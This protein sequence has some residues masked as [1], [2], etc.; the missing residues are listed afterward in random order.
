M[1]QSAYY[2]YKYYPVLKNIINTKTYMLVHIK[3]ILSRVSKLFFIISN[4]ITL[5]MFVTFLRP[6]YYVQVNTFQNG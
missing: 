6:T 3:C 1:K 4:N 2:L 5:N